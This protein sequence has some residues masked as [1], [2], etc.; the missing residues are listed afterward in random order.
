[1]RKRPRQAIQSRGNTNRGAQ[2]RI[3]E[4]LLVTK[5]RP[6]GCAASEEWWAVETYGVWNPSRH[7]G[8]RLCVFT[9]VEQIAAGLQ[10]YPGW[11]VL[12]QRLV[13]QTVGQTWLLQLTILYARF[14]TGLYGYSVSKSLSVCSTNFSAEDN[15]TMPKPTWPC[16]SQPDHSNQKSDHRYH[17]RTM[18]DTTTYQVFLVFFKLSTSTLIKILPGICLRLQASAWLF[19]A[20]V[21]HS[22]GLVGLSIRMVSSAFGMVSSTIGM[23]HWTFG[24]VT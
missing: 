14:D 4:K 9:R 7:L 8:W 12:D 23:V 11:G 5:D 22:F 19:L 2:R 3:M 6:P 10:V 20:L 1:M 18:T 15:L 17:S 21:R 13:W 16:Q 24:M